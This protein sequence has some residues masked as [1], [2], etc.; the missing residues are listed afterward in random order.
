MAK[1]GWHFK[2]WKWGLVFEKGEP[3]KVEYAVEIFYKGSGYDFKP[4]KNTEEFAEYCKE[5]GWEFV[6]YCRKY[7]IFKKISEDAEDIVTAKE[8]FENAVKE[9]VKNA[10]SQLLYWGLIAGINLKSSFID[11]VYYN[12]CNISNLFHWLIWKSV[13][14]S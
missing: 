1:E 6:D 9:E 4:D 11:A 8:H 2:E 12:A 14:C 3:E 10:Y 13:L 7:L 5:A